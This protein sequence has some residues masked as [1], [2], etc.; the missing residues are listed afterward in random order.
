PMASGCESPCMPLPS[1]IIALDRNSDAAVLL[2]HHVRKGEAADPQDGIMGSL[3]ITASTDCNLVLSRTDTS[4]TLWSRQRIGPDLDETVLLFEE[5]TGAI[6]L[7]DRKAEAARRDLTQRILDALSGA[8]P[9]GPTESE[10][11]ETVEGKTAEL[12]RA[13]GVGPWPQTPP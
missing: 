1:P 7:G 3:G 2:L 5:D 12:R 6:A 13:A 10:L 9:P 8:V 11:F 4:R